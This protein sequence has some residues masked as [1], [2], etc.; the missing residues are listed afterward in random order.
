M[1]RKILSILLLTIFTLC[2][3]SCRGKTTEAKVETE[4]DNP[5][6]A[7]S[8][9]NKTNN[10]SFE[11][12]LFYPVYY[13]DKS[14][15]IDTM[16]L[17]DKNGEKKSNLSE[18]IQSILEQNGIGFDNESLFGYHFMNGI[19][20]F[21]AYSAG[22]SIADYYALDIANC[23]TAKIICDEYTNYIDYYNGKLYLGFDRMLDKNTEYAF[24]IADDFSFVPEEINLQK[25]LDYTTEYEIARVP[26]CVYS[27][28]TGFSI[29]RALNEFGFVIGSRYNNEEKEYIKIFPDGTREEIKELHDKKGGIIY[30]DKDKIILASNDINAIEY[31][32]DIYTYDL[33]TKSLEHILN[34]EDK[35]II[36]FSD[37]KLYLRGKGNDGSLYVYDF[38]KQT[39]TLIYKYEEKPGTYIYSDYQYQIINSNI[40]A[41]DI[42]NAELKWYR[43]DVYEDT[44]KAVDIECPIDSIPAYKIGT[45]IPYNSETNCPFCGNK[46]L[47]SS[48]ELFQLND[49]YSEHTSKINEMLK[50]KKDQFL[51][52]HSE[53][54]CYI[55]DESD[56]EYHQDFCADREEY[57]VEANIYNSSFL[58]I[59]M[60][61]W[62]YGG[63]PHGFSHG[64]IYV[65]D[66]STTEEISLKNFYPGTESEF[67]EWFAEKVKEDYR[68]CPD[69]YSYDSETEAYNEAYAG[70]TF[71]PVDSSFIGYHDDYIT[72]GFG[73]GGSASADTPAYTID[74]PY[75]EL[76]GHAELTRVK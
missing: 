38:E 53:I 2:L 55:E 66:L 39:E 67:K 11:D 33:K 57:L 40:F 41:C 1:K 22:S 76:N 3:S 27:Q 75:E 65:F 48:Y 45:V 63:G 9:E 37:N 49:G 36:Q 58:V 31:A 17:I 29:S 56:C 70:A 16:Y 44:S 72:L 62:W 54:E 64:N 19:L 46:V 47:D 59:E 26:Y 28:Y 52:D 60:E 24:S 69:R 13:E 20:F 30:Y 6:Q 61:H 68:K 43:I 15:S 23:R 7:K 5:A 14:A 35:S 73:W 12:V 71:D 4:Q 42:E 34:I 32:N 21:R 25:V 74:I 10:N 51:N 50:K 18:K 8:S